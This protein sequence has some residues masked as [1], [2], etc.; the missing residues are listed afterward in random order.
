MS[1]PKDPTQFN[2]PDR[3]TLASSDVGSLGL[4][5]L[6]LTKELW[7]LTD[8]VHVME[9]VLEKHHLDIREEIKRYQPDDAMTAELRQE[10]TALIE[11]VLNALSKD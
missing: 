6:A 2:L 8:R 4:A 1:A 9:A 11:R 5:V 7:V 3:E 10:S